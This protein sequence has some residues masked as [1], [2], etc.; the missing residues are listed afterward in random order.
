VLT[1][2]VV[3][4]STGGAAVGVGGFYVSVDLRVLSVGGSA[5]CWTPRVLTD[6]V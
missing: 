1:H 2:C 3:I 6:S 4:C 5:D